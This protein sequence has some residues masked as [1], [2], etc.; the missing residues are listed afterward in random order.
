MNTENYMKFMKAIGH[1]IISSSSGYW[2]DVN[3]SFY[4]CMPPF[5]IIS[6]L[7]SE[8]NG[9][10]RKHF[11]VGIKYCAPQEKMGKLSWIYMCEE[12]EYDLKSVHPKMRNKVRQGMR[13]C[14][15]RP[16]TFDYLY[17]HGMALN[18]DTLVRQKRKEPLFTKQ[19]L[20]E[21]LC[22][23]GKEAEG[24]GVW[25]AFVKD[26]L[27]A[28]MITFQ[29][30]EYGNI[31]HQM[32]KTDLLFSHANNALGFVATKEMLA[33]SEIETVSYGQ[34]SIRHLPGLEEYKVRLGY[35]KV[36]MRYVVVMHPVIRAFV[37]SHVG[38]RVL[39]KMKKRY[40]EN[41]LLKQISGIFDIARQSIMHGYPSSGGTK[42]QKRHT[43]HHKGPVEKGKMVEGGHHG[44]KAVAGEKP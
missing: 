15:V 22:Q 28:Y 10:F 43:M 4:E 20:W 41:D 32:S 14:A 5:K 27:A 33:S 31:L 21:R 34:A 17:D 35:K 38:N 39:G 6:P 3:R 7:N 42:A 16:I 36:P 1:Q 9:L 11:M 19:K 30:N 8:V 40:P 29:I 44:F 26:Q 37:L 2:Y 12:K 24:A 13:N 23:A 18:R 25:G